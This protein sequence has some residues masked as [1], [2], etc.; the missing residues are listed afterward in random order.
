MNRSFLFL[1]AFLC[2]LFLSSCENDER[3]G[4]YVD[5]YCE[6]CS[7]TGTIVKS[8]YFGLVTT[9]QDCA[10]C[11]LLNKNCGNSNGYDISFK[12]KNCTYSVGCDC[13]GF[14]PT[15]DGD[16]W[17]ESICKKCKHGKTYHN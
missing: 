11:Y 13:P 3:T 6:W 9:Y 16:V 15:T 2:L 14:E 5:P 10:R 1:S 4:I 7:G 8:E 12:G 17:E